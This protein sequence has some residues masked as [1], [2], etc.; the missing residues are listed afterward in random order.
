LDVA[1]PTF[2]GVVLHTAG[3]H[4]FAQARANHHLP[5]PGDGQDGFDRGGLREGEDERNGRCTVGCLTSCHSHPA[6]R[7]FGSSQVT[8]WIRPAPERSSSHA[9]AARP[10]SGMERYRA[11]G[12]SRIPRAQARAAG[13]APAGSEIPIARYRAYHCQEKG[14]T[15]ICPRVVV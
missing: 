2:C 4:A 10:G 12:R 9:R 13:R 3:L 14:G 1:I 6:L 11:F 8:G 7:S 5:R 15:I